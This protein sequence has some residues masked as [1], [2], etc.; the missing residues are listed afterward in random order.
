MPFTGSFTVPDYGASSYGVANTHSGT[1]GGVPNTRGVNAWGDAGVAVAG[2]LISGF[3]ESR[4]ASAD[5]A[6]AAKRQESSARYQSYMQDVDRYNQ[7]QDRAYAEGG[8]AAYRER[9]PTSSGGVPIM[10]PTP[11]NPG[12]R[13]VDPYTRPRG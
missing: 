3:F 7:M 10:A 13:P 11:T 8:V 1:P 5:R 9:G 12:T 2:A 6:S 4:A